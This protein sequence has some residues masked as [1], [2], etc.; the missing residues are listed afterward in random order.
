MKRKVIQTL[1]RIIRYIVIA[2]LDK[3]RKSDNMTGK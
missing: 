1:K 2:V 3:M